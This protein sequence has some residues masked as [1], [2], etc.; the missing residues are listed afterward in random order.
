MMERRLAPSAGAGASRRR[1]S[2]HAGG[3]VSRHSG[4]A[5]D[6]TGS[7]RRRHASVAAARCWSAGSA[8]GARCA[9]RTE[10]ATRTGGAR[11]VPGRWSLC[12]SAPS[13]AGSAARAGGRCS[14]PS[15]QERA[16]RRATCCL[17]SSTD[18]YGSSAAPPELW[19]STTAWR[20]PTRVRQ[21]AA[22][23]AHLGAAVLQR[24]VPVR[25]VQAGRTSGLGAPQPLQQLA[26]TALFLH[27][28]SRQAGVLG[29]HP[30][31]PRAGQAGGRRGRTESATPSERKTDSRTLSRT[32]VR[33]RSSIRARSRASACMPA[34]RV[35]TLRVAG[36][37]GRGRDGK[38]VS[39]RR[40]SPQSI[41]SVRPPRR[42]SAPPA[43]TAA[44]AHR[45]GWPSGEKTD[46]ARRA[47][48]R[49]RRACGRARV[50]L[51]DQPKLG[52]IPQRHVDAVPQR[53]ELR[54]QPRV[55]NLPQ[56]SAERAVRSLRHRDA[57]AAPRAE[58][59]GCASHDT[60]LAAA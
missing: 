35:I 10:R 26:L 3:P 47:L 37:A 51:E 58:R 8:R 39:S 19:I 6:T 21:R 31:G 1:S 59:A 42:G 23:A 28:G 11:W 41:V 12:L 24:R 25:L 2:L 17:R 22:A 56:Q 45:G 34:Q 44:A 57:P 33:S 30:A 32:L 29:A 50:H 53:H 54:T 38:K 49:H 48:L 9:R 43:P 60:R 7:P 18:S 5:V 52:T 14:A 40:C 4:G 16:L 15:G 36:E 27:S 55:L 20:A 46:A 13:A